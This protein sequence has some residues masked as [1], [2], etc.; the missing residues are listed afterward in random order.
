[1]ILFRSFYGTRVN[2]RVLQGSFGEEA[3]NDLEARHADQVCI[4]NEWH[5][6]GGERLGEKEIYTNH[7]LQLR[8]VLFRS[9]DGRSRQKKQ[10]NSIANQ[11]ER[12][13]CGEPK[14]PCLESRVH[15][16]QC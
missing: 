10:R 8:A 13:G 6:Q 4:R 1:M 7:Q 11:W 3:G 2:A 15:A 14:V 16:V 12:R 9:S 5:G